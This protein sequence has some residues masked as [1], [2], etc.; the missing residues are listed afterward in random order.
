MWKGKRSGAQE[1]GMALPQALTVLLYNRGEGCVSQMWVQF[2]SLLSGCF[3]FSRKQIIKMKSD[4]SL[5]FLRH[6]LVKLCGG[7]GVD[8]SVLPLS[9]SCL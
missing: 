4:L 2:V 6:T 1:E 9:I 3:H 5:S 8:A 7:W